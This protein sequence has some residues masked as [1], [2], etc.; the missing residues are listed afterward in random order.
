MRK[1]G[2]KERRKEGTVKR[3]RVNLTREH[4]RRVKLGLTFTGVIYLVLS[5]YIL[6]WKTFS[7]EAK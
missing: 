2:M 4:N 5:L 7:S 3:D 1:E 6:Y